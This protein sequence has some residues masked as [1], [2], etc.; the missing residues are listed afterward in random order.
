M[1]TTTYCIAN[2]KYYVCF[3]FILFFF[4]APNELSNM[5]CALMNAVHKISIGLGK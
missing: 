1:T 2:G 5:L 3:D 4:P